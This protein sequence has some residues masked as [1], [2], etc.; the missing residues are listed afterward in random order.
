MSITVVGLGLERGQLTAEAQDLLRSGTRV[1]LRTAHCD[2][3]RWMREQGLAF[4]A[5]DALYDEAE[6]F[7]RLND[8]LA[9]RVTELAG[10]G[11]LIYGVLDL[12]DESVKRLA[13][14]AVRYVPGVPVDAALADSAL[15]PT[16]Q[17]AA[18]DCEDVQFEAGLNVL[19]R[20]IASR[21]L[22]SQLK[23]RLMERF[24]ERHPVL[25]ALGGG[26]IL[27]TTLDELDRLP[28]YDHRTC[29]FLSAERD[30]KKL[31]RYGFNELNRVVRILRGPDGCPWDRAQ[32]HAT[33]RMNA[34][35]EAWEVVDAIEADDTD[36]LYDELGDLVL[37]AALH[38]EIARQHGEFAIDDVTS[39]ITGKLIHR[40]RHVF[41]EADAATPEAGLRLWDQ[42]KRE[43]RKLKGK[44]E[45]MRAVTRALPQL[46]R[47]EKLLRHMDEPPADEQ[48][49]LRARVDG[50]GGA[51][52]A[53]LAIGELLL[54][55]VRLARSR[56]VKAE[57]ALGRALEALIARAA[58]EDSL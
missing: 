53:E 8:R 14:R 24:P 26:E 44:A 16:L 58:R 11:E 7:D 19:A 34:V 1:M 43:D 39:A 5:L 2:A 4:E 13:A 30:L 18:C 22:A 37:Q 56:G 52:D 41:G 49:A 23:L 31:T 29:A 51:D 32:T 33:I 28:D 15:G 17:L 27:T 45:A 38:A 3:A 12:R 54:S 55:V 36:A 50:L 57:L 20:E 48:A 10:D 21:E 9:A 25:L 42:I 47:A 46:M 35:E 6:D 40:H